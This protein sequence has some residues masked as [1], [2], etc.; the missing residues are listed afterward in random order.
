MSIIKHCQTVRSVYRQ[1]DFLIYCFLLQHYN[2]ILKIDFW[3]MRKIIL[4]VA[5]RRPKPGDS[6]I[7]GEPPLVTE[8][9]LTWRAIPEVAWGRVW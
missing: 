7:S 3:R 6:V 5:V 8:V 2:V 9:I 4:L 1:N